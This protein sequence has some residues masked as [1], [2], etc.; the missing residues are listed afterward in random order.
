MLRV[1]PWCLFEQVAAAV[2]RDAGGF[3]RDEPGYSI[4]IPEEDTGL[5]LLLR[6]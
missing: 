6:Q 2:I 5:Q 3:S 4:R 1:A